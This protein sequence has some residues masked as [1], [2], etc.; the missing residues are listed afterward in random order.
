MAQNAVISLSGINPMKRL[1][2]ALLVCGFLAAS[3]A[4]AAPP[5]GHAKVAHKQ[6]KKAKKAKAHKAA[7]PHKA[8]RQKSN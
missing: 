2:G 8:A 1:F 5:K 7:K 4:Q 6:A 3:V